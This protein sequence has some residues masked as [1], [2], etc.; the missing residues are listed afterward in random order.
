MIEAEWQVVLNAL[1]EQNTISRM[2]LYNG[3]SRNCAYA[4]K[5]NGGQ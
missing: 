1:L 4:R 5:G 2:H 3:R